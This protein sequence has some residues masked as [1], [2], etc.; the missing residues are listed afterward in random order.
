MQSCLRGRARLANLLVSASAMTLT[1]WTAASAQDA[2]TAPASEPAV[3]TAGEDIVVTGTRRADTSVKDTP[4]AMSAFSGETLERNNVTSLAGLQSLDPSVNIQSYGAAQ[5]KIVLRGIDSNVG[6]TTALYLNEAA[7]L[8]GIGGNILGDGKPGIRLHDI[9]HVEVLKGPQGTLFGTSSMSGTLRVITRKPVLDDFSLSG[10]LGVATVKGGNPFGEVNATVNVPLVTDTLGLRVTAWSEIGGGYVDQVIK[11][12]KR[13]SDANDAFVR[14]VRGELLYKPSEQFSLL[15]FVLHQR[16]NVDGTQAFQAANGAHLNTSPTIELYRDKYTL[17]SLT[18]DYD[19]G[20]G[21]IIASGSYSRQNVLNAKD[22]TPTNLSFGVNADLSFVPRVWFKD[23]NAELRFSSKFDGP[24]QIVAG[25]YYEY[26]NNVYQTNAIQAPN[27]I[28]ACFSFAQCRPFVRP[29]PG[30]SIYE[31]GTD[32]ERTVKQYAAYAQADYKL[33]DTLTATVGIRY[34][35]ADIRDVITNLQTVF[36]DFV[37]G[38]VTT[39]SVTGDQKGSN[40][41]PSYNASLLWQASDDISVFVRAASGFRVG[42]VNTATSLAQ[43]AG[44]VFPGEYKPDSLWSYEAGVKGY[45]ANRAIYFDL[46]AYRVDWKNQQLSASAAGAFAYTINA[47][48]TRSNGIE[49]NTTVR[50]V[51]G[52]SVS[53]SVTYVDSKLKEDLPADVVAAGTIGSAGDRVPLSPRWS[54]SA[55]AEYETPLNASLD[56]YVAGSMNY[57]GSS[58]STFN[59]ATQFDTFLPSYTLFSARLGVRGEGWEAG[60]YGENLTDKAPYLGVVPSLDGVRVFTVRP[61]TIGARFKTDL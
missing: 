30:N 51:A 56:G 5:T 8:G 61:R 19:L 11:D 32:N 12:T 57:K 7:V 3:E 34:F 14:G 26:T 39:P 27:A 53:G 35:K 43:Q 48:S 37:F 6:A 1:S 49:F 17:M 45:L 21:S 44:V 25:G 38:N 33:V 22:S 16:V 2:A 28:P 52:L 41:K 40:K 15:A 55:S 59:R 36:P 9:A 46:T 10:Q 60:I 13:Y 23:Y 50:P 4:I 29:G 20:F 42:G 58:Y 18:A 47:G 54:A 24:F 31:F